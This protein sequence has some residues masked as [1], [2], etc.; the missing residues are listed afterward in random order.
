MTTPYLHNKET[1]L[2]LQVKKDLD[3]HEGYRE[4]AYPDPL[5][6]LGKKYSSKDYRWGFIPGNEILASIPGAKEE[7]GAPWTMGFGFTHGVNS[8]SRIDRI[9]AERML[10][11]LIL[12]IK[13]ALT[14]TLPWFTGASFV[15]QTIMINM[16]FNLGMK[17]FLK[18]KNTL[19]YVKAKQYVS[20]ASNMRHSLWYKQVGYRAEE[21][22]QR[23]ET[24]TID[25]A[26]KAQECL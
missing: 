14:K 2:L 21:L 7:D 11:E 6:K 1:K 15:T 23:M 3:R 4:F 16:V 19:A 20:A 18:F 10:E 5:S 26:H 12:N 17:G 24:Q 13:A 9:R 8:A 22:A 25:A